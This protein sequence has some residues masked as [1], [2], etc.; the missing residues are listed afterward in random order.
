MTVGMLDHCGKCGVETVLKLIKGSV[1]YCELC[2]PSL[3][4]TRRRRKRKAWVEIYIA[5]HLI[6]SQYENPP[7]VCKD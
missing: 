2:V 6:Y 5:D 1:G 7:L 3:G 4:R